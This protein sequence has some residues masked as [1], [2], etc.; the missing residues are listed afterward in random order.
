MNG[1]TTRKWARER[2]DKMGHTIYGWKNTEQCGRDEIKKGGDC[3]VR[4]M[5]LLEYDA[6]SGSLAL[7]VAVAWL[8]CNFN[9]LHVCLDG[10]LRNQSY[11][12]IE[13]H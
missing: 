2:S 11:C 7:V 3:V 4:V 1:R 12:M 13:R 10:L 8:A 6:K 9:C 5:V